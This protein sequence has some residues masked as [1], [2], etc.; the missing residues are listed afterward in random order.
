MSAERFDDLAR[1]LAHGTTRRQLLK[2]FA[3]GLGATILTTLGRHAP[4]GAPAVARAQVGAEEVFLPLIRVDGLDICPV[5]SSCAEKIIC[6][7]RGSNCRCLK[8]AEGVI[9][10]GQVPSCSAQNCTTSAD[11]ANLGP[12]YF[13]DSLGSGCCGDEL[14]RCI[15][16]CPAPMTECPEERLCGS[17]CCPTGYICKGGRCVDPLADVTTEG[18]WTGTL[19]DEGESIGIRFIIEGDKPEVVGRMLMQ[20]PVT[21]EWLETGTISGERTNLFAYWSTEGGSFIAGELDGDSFTGYFQFADYNGEYGPQTELM[22][23]RNG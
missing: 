10:C 18:T 8:S 17:A 5:A 23:Q 3:A 14:Q 20:D 4:A 2:G 22:I 21:L 19:T 1:A 9:R 13:C 11:C 16:P 15:A 6:S 12:D 7:E